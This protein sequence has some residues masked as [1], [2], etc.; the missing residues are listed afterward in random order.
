MKQTRKSLRLIA[1]LVATLLVVSGC[2]SRP[3]SAQKGFGLELTSTGIGITGGANS[4]TQFYGFGCKKAI[5]TLGTKRTPITKIKRGITSCDLYRIKGTPNQVS[6][7]SIFQQTGD[8]PQWY[9]MIYFDED[10]ET[11]Y[12]FNENLLDKIETKSRSN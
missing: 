5:A 3:P 1:S 2:T 11:K 6:S 9:E 4:I 8:I 10:V 7:I 12:V